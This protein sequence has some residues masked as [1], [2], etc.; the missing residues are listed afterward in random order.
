VPPLE[1]APELLIEDACPDVQQPMCPVL[2]PWLRTRLWAQKKQ[3]P[4]PAQSWAS[5]LYDVSDL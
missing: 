2:G 5:D 3:L 4:D 1:I